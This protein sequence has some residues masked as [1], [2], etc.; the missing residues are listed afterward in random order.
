MTDQSRQFDD[1]ELF[2]TT[3]LFRAT[4][5]PALEL[6]EYQQRLLS[7]AEQTRI[8][9]HVQGCQYCQEELAQLQIFLQQ[10]DP[11]LQ[12][13]PLATLRQHA[14]ALVGRLVNAVQGAGQPGFSPALAGLRGDAGGPLVY[15]AGDMQISI[16]IQGDA[17][18]PGY[19]ALFGLLINLNNGHNTLAELWNEEGLVVDTPVDA[20]GN[21]AFHQ[22]TPGLYELF[23]AS[24]MIDIHIPDLKVNFA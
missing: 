15:E 16:E 24:E 21:F 11:Y 12:P 6:S 19:L 20:I 17:E 7:P 4:C 23:I 18:H 14:A 13:D 2:M 9:G 22:L 10:P 3:Q 1:F 5:P 8:T